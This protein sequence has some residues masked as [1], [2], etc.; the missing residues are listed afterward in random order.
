[1]HEMAMGTC[2]ICSGK[3]PSPNSRAAS[4]VRTDRSFTCSVCERSLPETKFPTDKAGDRAPE[5][6]RECRDYLVA[7]HKLEIS[8]DDAIAKRRREFS[9]PLA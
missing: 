5:R 4:G 6:C 2:S 8:D 1:M 7:Q 9:A 3:D